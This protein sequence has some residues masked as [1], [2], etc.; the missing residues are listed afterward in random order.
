MKLRCP[1]CREPGVPVVGKLLLSAMVWTHGPG[2]RCTRCGTPVRLTR[3]AVHAQFVLYVAFLILLG[4][5]LHDANRLMLAYLG[6]AVILIV[7]LLAP[8]ERSVS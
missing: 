5:S 7:G 1:D 2:T 3:S 8:L 6:A 4:W